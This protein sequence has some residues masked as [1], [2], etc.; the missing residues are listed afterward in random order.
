[1]AALVL[2]ASSSASCSGDTRNEVE[3]CPV[4]QE[5]SFLCSSPAALESADLVI[6]SRQ[7]SG[8]TATLN[9]QTPCEIRCAEQVICLNGG[10][11]PFTFVENRLEF[12]DFIRC[13]AGD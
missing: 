7:E 10:C 6:T 13:T 1:M 8:C 9:R 5:V 4:C 11:R 12:G 3:T 2:I